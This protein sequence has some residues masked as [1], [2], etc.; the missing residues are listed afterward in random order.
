MST[1]YDAAVGSVAVFDRPDRACLA[2][3]GRAPG[4]MLNGI[5]TGST[6]AEPERAEDGSLHGFASYTAALTPKGKLITDGRL[7]LRGSEEDEGFI[8]EVPTTG[9][10]PLLS[11]L[12]KFLPPRMASV[13]DLTGELRVASLVGPEAAEI[14]TSVVF[15]GRVPSAELSG[16]EEGAWR[17][18]GQSDADR[19]TV[20]RWCDVWPEAF[21]VLGATGAIRRLFDL[22]AASG[23]TRA[24]PEAWAT[25][26]IEAG[27]PAFGVEMNE[28]TIPVEAGIHERAIDY[29]KGCYTGQEVIVRIRDRGHVNRSL[30]LVRLGDTPPPA[31]GTE[32]FAPDS[33]KSAGTVASSVRSPRFG[34]TVALAYVR[35]GSEDVDLSIA[36]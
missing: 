24:E 30:R 32:L 13:A 4:Q 2:I 31:A 34:E 25:L 35:R 33:E 17:E 1:G 20:V 26:R 28:D 8:L 19:M 11:H 15:Q 7:W 22:L 27:R 16:L 5:L 29:T 12:G 9:R 10:E 21:D 14:L 23:V 18:A 36:G 3:A 6:P